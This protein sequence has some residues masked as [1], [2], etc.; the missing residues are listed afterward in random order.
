VA[1]PFFSKFKNKFISNFKND[2][3]ISNFLC[4]INK[5]FLGPRLPNL[6]KI[7][8]ITYLPGGMV[9]RKR[10]SLVRACWIKLTPDASRFTHFNSPW[11]PSLL[12]D[13][14]VCAGA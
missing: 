11:S 5:C 1:W 3:F 4:A 12:L 10:G 8:K 14:S 9:H 2:F 6:L 7:V 13:H